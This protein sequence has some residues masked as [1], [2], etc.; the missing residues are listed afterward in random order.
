[1]LF[2][3]ASALAVMTACTAVP[4]FAQSSM[5]GMDMPSQSPW[6]WH[7]HGSLSLI[8]DGQSGPRGGDKTFFAG[9]I[10]AMANRDFGNNRLELQA[11]LSPDPFMGRAGY[12]LLLQTGETAD[13]T[14]HLVD[15][16]H[17]HDLIMGLSARLTHR[18]EDGSSVFGSVGYPGETPFGPTAFMH[19]ASGEDFP[20]APISHHWLDSGHITMG[21]VTGGFSKGPVTLEVAQFTGREPDQNRFD[22]DPVRLDSTAVRLWWQVTPDLKAQASWARQVSPEQLEP[23][24]NLRKQSLSVEYGHGPVNATIAW[25]CKQAEH[26]T[27]KPADAWL[28]EARWHVTDKWSAL[29]RYERVYNDELAATPYWVAKTEIGG[30][31][32]FA[33]DDMTSVNLGLIRQFNTV[34]DALKPAYGRHPDG[35]VA[36]VTLKFHRMKM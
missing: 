35:T 23:D 20:T 16:Q 27:E 21:V 11:M 30:Y 6:Q 24:V 8:A 3:T 15:R 34:P 17:P 1:M 18:F 5:P 14:T 13:G 2:R 10:M 25:A 19:R 12:P 28:A 22:L 32:T 33:I 31:R 26:G 36:F 4:A 29:G 9:M 7:V